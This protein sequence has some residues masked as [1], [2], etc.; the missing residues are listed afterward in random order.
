MLNIPD[1]I[2][3]L[4]KADVG[5]R[6]NFRVRFPNGELPDITN[7]NIVQESVKFTESLC[8]QQYLRF[9]LAEAPT[10]E[11][12]TV[13]IGNMY[14]M[15][16]ECFS[17]IET[18]SLSAQDIADIQAMTD[19]DGELVLA[20]DSDIGFG[21][22]RLPLGVFTV[23]SCPRSHGAMKHRRVNALGFDVDYQIGLSA[24]L[25]IDKSPT[26]KVNLSIADF[27]YGAYGLA[28]VPAQQRQVINMTGIRAGAQYTGVTVTAT[29]GS[30]SRTAYLYVPKG[31]Y[32]SLGVVPYGGIGITLTMNDEADA[33]A[34][35]KTQFAQGVGIGGGVYQLL[36]DWKIDGETA[37]IDDVLHL[38]YQ[39]AAA[40]LPVFLAT[41]NYGT[42]LAEEQFEYGKQYY[43]YRNTPANLGYSQ[44]VRAPF[45]LIFSFSNTAPVSGDSFIDNNGTLISESIEY[46]STSSL[47]YQSSPLR[48]LVVEIKKDDI[49]HR[50]LLESSAELLA[51]FARI[52]R[53]GI[54]E[55]VVLDKSP[56]IAISP[57]LY[58]ELWWDEYDV[59]PIGIVRYAYKT[60][61]AEFVDYQIG[62][63]ESIYDMTDNYIINN[64][65]LD[66]GVE[67][68]A[69]IEPIIETYFKP[70]AEDVYYTPTDCDMKGLPYIESGDY[71]EI[72]SGDSEGGEAIKAKTYVMD[73]TLQGIQVLEDSIVSQ[74]GE[75]I[76]GNLYITESE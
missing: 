68:P 58:S 74:G 19:L 50:K 75:I 5:A 56:S 33:I 25:A 71:L 40:T 43:V 21:F 32:L 45:G 51:E 4:Y 2:K 70:N 63:G 9:G 67:L 41:D 6:K 35:F 18:T 54:A 20:A 38:C 13:G 55:R 36:D 47:P 17:E 42:V 46:V 30:T 44:S 16:I 76:S 31:E 15:K 23:E 53:R 28:L 61:D 64:A 62:D 10:I 14:G 52:G 3:N 73:R 69:I 29:Y 34:Y 24:A 7:E 49:D 72:D 22:Y 66:K 59:S 39:L 60:D 12:E 57:D 8:S 37:S 65:Y 26:E 27:M 48:R 11:F 1:A